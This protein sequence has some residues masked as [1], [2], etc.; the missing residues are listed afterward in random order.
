[1]ILLHDK[2]KEIVKSRKRFKVA[3]A[4]RKGGKTAVEVE[5][6]AYKAT[7]SQG[8]LDLRTDKILKNRKVLYI[9]PTQIQARK[10]IWE[11]LK[12]RLAGLGEPSE[13][14]L[15]IKVP[16]ADGYTSTI[17]VGGWENREN[18][19]G[20]TEVVHISFDELDTMKDFY[21]GWMEIF[22]PM[23]LDTGGTADFIGTPK[24][25]NPNLKRMVKDFQESGESYQEF[26]FTSKDNP[27]IDPLEIEHAQQTMDPETYRQE[28]LAEYVENQGALFKFEALVDVFS[29]TIIKEN[30]KYL[31]IDVA[32]DGS[33]KIIF[34]FWEGLEEY[35]RES[36]DRLNT[37][38]IISKT[39]E[40]AA[41]DRIPYSHIAVDAIGVGTGVATSSLLDG[42]IGFKSSYAP[43]KTDLDP[44]RV[45]N[46]GYLP[47]A[48]ILTS[49]YANL[50]SQCVFVLAD[51][52]N[53]HKIASR[54]SGQAKERVIEELSV[55]QDVSKGDGK[56]M[57][58]KKEDVK[59]A[60][61]R[62]PDDSDTWIMRMYFHVIG[63]MSPHQ[64]EERNQIASK[65]RNQFLRN[66]ANAVGTK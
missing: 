57:P 21:S 3:R 37:E 60:I 30:A 9:A 45:P 66:R 39:R 12:S 42:I 31:T 52:V 47:K 4:G 7:V 63:R 61:G 29:N 26:H 41:Q 8:N 44:T 34:S 51:L 36:F 40:Y 14:R 23:F 11:E 5:T 33:D 13:Q 50:R 27:Y 62:S 19:R 25:E 15:E 22:R 2:Q 16:N 64:S 38:S 35:R 32:E 17:Y 43:I 46:A 18:Y 53:N 6:I 58:T 20:M 54:V 59:E 65:Q 28:I 49:D 10:I 56:R 55:Y 1:M 24:K 48:P